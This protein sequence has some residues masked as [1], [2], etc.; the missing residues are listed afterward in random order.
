L[1]P[2][3][4]AVK[5]VTVKELSTEPCGVPVINPVF[6]IVSAGGRSLEE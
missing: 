4:K 3:E 2:E 6:V 5:A 1:D